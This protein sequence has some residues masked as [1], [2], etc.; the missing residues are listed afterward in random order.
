MFHSLFFVSICVYIFRDLFK[1]ILCFSFCI[2]LWNIYYMHLVWEDT[3][4]GLNRITDF[5]INLW[6]SFQISFLNII[7]FGHGF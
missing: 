4:N 3:E 5:L 1:I 6:N 7:M 2:T